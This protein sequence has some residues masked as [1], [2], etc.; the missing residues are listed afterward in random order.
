MY[1]QL[2][3]LWFPVPLWQ[4]V[5]TF[6]FK[7]LSS[8]SSFSPLIFSSDIIFSD[9]FLFIIY[10]SKS[11][12]FFAIL[13]RFQCQVLWEIHHLVPKCQVYQPHFFQFVL[14]LLL[15]HTS[16]TCCLHSCPVLWVSQHT[17]LSN[18]QFSWSHVKLSTC[19]FIDNLPRSI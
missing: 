2:T 10:P 9:F 18:I 3:Y 19:V 12:S 14:Y 7:S 15:Q 8:S 16:P 11:C 5:H 6:F 17:C 1:N 4:P 13:I